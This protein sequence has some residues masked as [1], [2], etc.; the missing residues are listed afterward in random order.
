MNKVDLKYKI[1][2][3]GKYWAGINTCPKCLFQPDVITTEIIGF[4]DTNNGLMT[5]V[6][7]PKCF[8]KWYFHTRD[9]EH[10]TYYYF[11]QSIKHGTQRHFKL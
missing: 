9:V 6:E 10:G 4:A 5:V 8:H 1:R 11:L 2:I 7:C 3:K